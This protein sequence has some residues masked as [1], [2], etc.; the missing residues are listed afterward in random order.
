MEYVRAFLA[1]GLVCVIAQLLIDRGRWTPAGVASLLVVLGVILG[2]GGVYDR[3]VASV[4]AGAMLPLSGLGY[5]FAKGVMV[6]PQP[7]GL[8]ATGG[9][10]FRFAG[11]LLAFMVAGSFA[12]A[13]ICKPKG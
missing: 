1:G 5:V 7:T 6:G 8:V 9:A 11:A 12:A 3:W 2:F 10:V 4:G 13:L